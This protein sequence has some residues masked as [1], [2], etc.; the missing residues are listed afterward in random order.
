MTPLPVPTEHAIQT[1][2]LEYLNYSGHW[3]L[4]V[5]SGQYAIDDGFHR[6]RFMKGAPA[7]TSDIV[8]CTKDGRFF[9]IECKRPGK[10]PTPQQEYFLD[11][12]RDKGGI[13]IVATCLEDV[14][15]I[16]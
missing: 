2:I 14:S 4:R 9:A 11:R 12:I 8:G 3:A 16:L 15:S 7:G 1:S 5:N 10:K 6:R 13:T